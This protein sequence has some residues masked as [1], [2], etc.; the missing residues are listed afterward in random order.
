MS[1]SPTTLLATWFGAGFLRPAPGTWGSLAA[2]PLAWG[3]S[4]LSGPLGIGLAA[5]AVTL[6]GIW[7]AE[8]YRKSCGR[9]DPSEVVIDEVAGQ[10]L[11][12]IA[13]APDILAYTAGFFLFRLFDILKPGPI[14]WADREV[15]GGLGIML[16]DVFAGLLSG[17]LLWGLGKGT[18][19][20][21]TI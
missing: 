2:L 13:V 21:T 6:L 19:W 4:S 14:G 10:L 11:T 20:W 8:G 5:L 9:E 1:L 3:L 7:A 12:L 16:D 18:G 15:K 17:V